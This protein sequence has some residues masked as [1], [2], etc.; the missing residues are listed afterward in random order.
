MTLE[1]D[2]DYVLPLRWADDEG[3]D[4]LT[5]YL[6]WL[7]GQIR[8][9]VVDG[10][11]APLWERHHVA[12]SQHVRHVRPERACRNGK[13]A[14]VLTGMG[15]VSGERVVVAD[16]DV[17]YDDQSLR[18]VLDRLATADVVAPQN[19]FEPMPWHT[20]WDTARSLLNRAFAADYPGTLAVRAST[21]R[22]M[23]GYDGDVLFENLELMRTV[24]A[25]GGRVDRPRWLYVRRRPP[26]AGRFWSQ[27]VRQA[28][29]DLAQ[30]ARLT[31][32]LAAGPGALW[33]LATGRAR[34]LAGS[35]AG[36]VLLA[37]LGRRRDGGRTVYP[38]STVLFAPLWVAE[39]AVCVWWA[40][41]LRLTRGG[42]S[43]AGQ[44]IRVAAHRP[45]TIRR[46]L[47]AQS[48]RPVR[49]GARGAEVADLVGPVA[50]RFER[51]PTAPAQGHRASAAVDHLT[52][53]GGQPEV[54]AH[55][56]WPVPV[57]RDRRRRV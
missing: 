31:W 27:R 55:Q 26:A 54:A 51:G 12:W 5:D 10:S 46:R 45:R 7:S 48:A 14:G 56:E 47:A 49:P 53:G 43:Y 6:R 39:R 30:P 20:R 17:R 50:E 23:G 24:R 33:L 19:V 42:V 57:R 29:D 25:A 28:Y 2:A 44:R 11:P 35:A 16:D 40:V 1:P 15:L 21:F 37:E 41:G 38:P 8:V 34:W 32:S 22:A 3:L 4:E 52:A 36:T 9:L 18:A 13:V